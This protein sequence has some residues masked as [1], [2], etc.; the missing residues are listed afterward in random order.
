MP[1][2]LNLTSDK[3]SCLLNRSKSQSGG[4]GLLLQPRDN[5]VGG[6]ANDKFYTCSLFKIKAIQNMTLWTASHASR[7][8]YYRKSKIQKSCSHATFKSSEAN[9]HVE[10]KESNNHSM[11]GANT[12]INTRWEQR[13]QQSIES[14]QWRA[15]T[16]NIIMS[17]KSITCRLHIL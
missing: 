8:R 11:L 3:C 15:S 6:P 10:S 5:C 1:K 16:I 13:K 17:M 12:A 9:T 4:S 14:C 2:L 7:L